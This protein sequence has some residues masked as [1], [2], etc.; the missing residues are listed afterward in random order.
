MSKEIDELLKEF[1]PKDLR[2]DSYSA[3]F[4]GAYYS[5]ITHIPSGIRVG[6]ETDGLYKKGRK[7]ALKKLIEMVKEHNEIMQKVLIG[8]GENKWTKE[9]GESFWR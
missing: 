6:F 1:N 8:D 5:R 2:I 9:P 4:N 3:P 7:E